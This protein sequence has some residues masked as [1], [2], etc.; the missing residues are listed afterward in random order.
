[1]QMLGKNL[2]VKPSVTEDLSNRAALYQRGDIFQSI[3][4]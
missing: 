2:G 4:F 3:G 1:M